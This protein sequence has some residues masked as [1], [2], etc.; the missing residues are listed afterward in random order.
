M[1]KILFPLLAVAALAASPA[2]Y[3]RTM[4][5]SDVSGSW[6][7]LLNSNDR[8]CFAAN[9]M[10]SNGEVTIGGPYSSESKALGAIGSKIQCAN[11]QGDY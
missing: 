5:D 4:H 11:P 2:A 3:A 7:V 6:H 9:R 10:A 1:K 8:L